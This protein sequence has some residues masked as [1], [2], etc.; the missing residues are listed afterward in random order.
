[1]AFQGVHVTNLDVLSRYANMYSTRLNWNQIGLNDTYLLWPCYKH[2]VGITSSVRYNCLDLLILYLKL[3]TMSVFSPTLRFTLQLAGLLPVSADSLSLR[4][5]VLRYSKAW[6]CHTLLV[7]FTT[8][9]LLYGWCC[10]FLKVQVR[11][12]PFKKNTR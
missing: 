6:V 11:F 9:V 3:V 2:I 7:A 12:R 4:G 10:E 5:E 1:M 8:C